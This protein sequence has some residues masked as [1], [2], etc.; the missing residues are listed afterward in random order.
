MN[1]SIAL[2]LA[3]AAA[4]FG[5]AYLAAGTCMAAEEAG[6]GAARPPGEVRITADPRIEL[7]VAVELFGGYEDLHL[8]TPYDVAY[9]EEMRAYFAPYRDHEAVRLFHEMS[10][11]GF[12]YGAPV[13]AVLALGDPPALE[14]RAAPTGLAVMQA[15]GAANVRRFDE[16]LR[17]FATDSNFAAFYDAHRAFYEET[18]ASVGA[19]FDFPAAV[20]ALEAFTGM[21]QPNYNL[22]VS[23]ALHPG[24]YGPRVG[25]GRGG[26]TVY[27]VIGPSGAKSGQPDFGA[28]ARMHSLVC[29]EFGHSFVNPLTEKHLADFPGRERVMKALFDRGYLQGARSTPRR[30]TPTSC[31]ASA[32]TSTSTAPWMRASRSRTSPARRRWG[33]CARTTGT[34]SSS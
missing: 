5:A 21:S 2:K 24:G 8:L 18:A 33:S 32:S 31:G 6:S 15:K 13:E 30:S 19:S 28:A 1:P 4:A 10:D 7:L 12:R 11:G 14:E 9:K 29:H 20:A 17:R 22:I 16:A 25:D 34:G 26:W 3:A 23:P 27:S